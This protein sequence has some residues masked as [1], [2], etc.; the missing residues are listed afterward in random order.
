MYRGRHS[1]TLVT[2]PAQEP[3]SV[4]DAKSWAR[5]DDSTDDFSL[6]QLVITARMAAEEYMRRSLITQTLKL[7]LDLA[8]TALANSLPEGVYDLPI[9]ALYGVLPRALELPKGP[10]QS[11][12]S[13]VTYDITNT[14]STYSPTYYFVDTVGARIVLNLG[15]I[16]PPNMRQRQACEVIYVTGYGNTASSVPQP[17]KTGIMIHAASLYEQRGQAQDQMDLPP[18]SK[19]LYNQY[20]ILG[21]RD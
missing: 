8:D 17:I 4:S 21:N 5:I 15:S 13:I 2:A 16:W 3:V 18:A 1:I 11:V 7:T 12:T 20:R 10:V 9:M 19:Q 14:S 6:Q